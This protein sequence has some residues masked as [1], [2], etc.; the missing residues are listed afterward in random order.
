MKRLGEI[1]LFTPDVDRLVHFYSRVLG[2]EPSAW[3]PGE[4]ATFMLGDVK[5]FLHRQGAPSPDVP[6]NMDHIAFF[7]ED[8]DAECEALQR[9]GLAAEIG[10]RDFSWGRSAYLSDPDGRQVELHRPP[11]PPRR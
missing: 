3:Q 8:V 10:P 2:M 4:T 9:Q 5:L 7:V 11:A 1:A 6:P